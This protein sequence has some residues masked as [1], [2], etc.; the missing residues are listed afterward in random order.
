MR[1][2]QNQAGMRHR[3]HHQSH[4][5][6]IL[7]SNAEHVNS[8]QTVS[9]RVTGISGFVIILHMGIVR[10]LCAN[11]HSIS[12][13][14]E[15]PAPGLETGNLLQKILEGSAFERLGHVS[16]LSPSGETL[17][18]LQRTHL[19]PFGC[20]P[21]S[22][23]AIAGCSRHAPN[24]RAASGQ[25][26][27]C[28]SV[29]MLSACCCREHRC[30]IAGSWHVDLVRLWSVHPSIIPPMARIAGADSSISPRGPDHYNLRCR[31]PPGDTGCG[32]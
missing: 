27:C 1:I 23:W 13:P 4:Q 32:N 18:P 20:C 2:R 6:C 22:H 16:H 11:C 3:C 15:D 7:V 9:G 21:G 31:P 24:T 19:L 30:M 12:A 26:G 10:S 28:R 14:R 5:G 8:G 25:L 17:L 29:A